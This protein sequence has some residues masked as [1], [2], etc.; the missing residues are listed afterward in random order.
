MG[1]RQIATKILADRAGLENGEIHVWNAPLPDDCDTR[2]LSK[3]LQ[4]EERARAAALAF[5]LDSILY[6]Q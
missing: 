6:V 2:E 3:L 5:D 1:R 4:P